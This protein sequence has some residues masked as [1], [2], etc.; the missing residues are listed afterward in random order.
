MDDSRRGARQPERFDPAKAGA[1]D[2]PTRFGYLSVPDVESLLALPKSGILIDFGAG[3]GAYARALARLRP[4]I[5]IHALDEQPAMLAL[6]KEKL[7]ARP[8]PNLKPE[9]ADEPRLKSLAG[10]ADAVLALNVLHELGDEA[11]QRLRGLLKAGGRAVFIDWNADIERPVGPPRGH[12]FSAG[13]ARQRLK[14]LGW[15][16]LSQ[17]FFPY[18]YVLIAD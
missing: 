18:H 8:L 6:L 7:A 1:L 13:Q 11:L 2:D 5:F 15:N 4:D 10:Q 9:L 17:R 16:V 12:V 3:T 14:S